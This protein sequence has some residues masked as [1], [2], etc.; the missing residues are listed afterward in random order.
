M[1]FT[2]TE[3]RSRKEAGLRRQ[4]WVRIGAHWKS[5]AREQSPGRDA[6]LV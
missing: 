1:P 3:N 2:D 5:D 6:V 4:R